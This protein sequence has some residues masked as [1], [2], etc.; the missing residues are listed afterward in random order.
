PPTAAVAPIRNRRR[1]WLTSPLFIM[2]FSHQAMSQPARTPTVCI[3]KDFT[4]QKYKR[5]NGNEITGPLQVV[6]P[7]AEPLVCFRSISDFIDSETK[8]P[9]IKPG[10]SDLR[11]RINAW[12]T[13]DAYAPSAGQPSSAQLHGHHG[14]HNPH[15]A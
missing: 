11:Q 8:N 7:L 5:S 10:F 14:L 12:R 1:P 15:C 4:S 9:A 13:E 2:V 6:K 3:E